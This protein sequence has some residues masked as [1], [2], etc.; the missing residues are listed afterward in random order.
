MKKLL[1]FLLILALMSGFLAVAVLADDEV[2]PDGNVVYVTISVAG[3][4]VAPAVPVAVT[5]LDGDG[6]FNVDEVLKCAHDQLYP[7]GAEAGYASSVGTWGLSLNMLW[8]DTSGNFGYYV[9]NA[10]VITDLTVPVE[11]GGSVYAFVYADTE[12]WSDTLSYFDQTDAV[13][14]DGTLTL[15]LCAAFK[16]EYWNVTIAP[17]AGATITIDGEAT[18]FVTDENGQVTV[19]F[20]AAG[21]YLLSAVSDDVVLIPPVC[22]VTAAQA[23][24]PA[25]DEVGPDNNVVYVTIS[26]AGEIK[27]PSVPVAVSDLNADGALDVDETLKCAHDQLY[28]GGA[29]AGYASAYSEYGLSLVMLWG[30]TSFAFGYLV[31]DAFCWSLADPVQAGDYVY[32]F[33]YS[34]K[35]FYSD[36]Y[37]YFDK[38]DAV[39][40]DGTLSLTLSASGYDESWNPITIS[41]AGAT[42]TI[43]GAAS[44]FVTDE[45]G[46][47][48]VSFDATGSYLL[49]AVSDDA[50][51]VPAICKVTVAKVPAKEPYPAYSPIAPDSMLEGETYTVKEG[52]TIRSISKDFYGTMF[53]WRFIYEANYDSMMG[54]AMVYPGQELFIPKR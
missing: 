50:I 29:E 14:E 15:T 9:D 13:A 20:D 21:S 46:Q 40:E 26:V 52:D 3:E 16:D 38:T 36:S 31:N 23:A 24:A 48:T 27:A 35:E 5:D 7:G 6:T 42:I 11:A 2:G 39:A 18:E 8:G 37:A 34:D 54:N 41:V 47:V 19:S 45:N 12:F 53:L 10:L 4:I 28:P 1:S 43:D 33:V 22:K 25:A 30:D 17:C 51:L 44:K 49:S 32:A